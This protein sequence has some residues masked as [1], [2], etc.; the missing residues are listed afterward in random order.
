M[1][2]F[3][4]AHKE[5]PYRETEGYVPLHVG[6]ASGK[7]LPYTADNTGDNISEKN[8]NFCEL[9]GLYW[10]WKNSGDDIKGLVHYR[11]YFNGASGILSLEEARNIL[12]SNDIILAK[13]EYL[14]E[15]AYEEFSLHSGHAHDLDLL[16]QAVGKVDSSYLPAYD[17]IF[18][19]NRLHLYNMMVAS[20]EIFD[21]YCEW[22]FAVLFELE[23]HVC[24][25]GYTPYEQ[26]LYGFLSERLLNVFVEHKKLKV[27][28]LRVKNTEQSLKESVKLFLRRQKNRLI[29]ALNK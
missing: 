12:K 8:P 27:K 28:P 2:I 3:I 11:R 4:A 10:I 29:F 1:A 23:K 25:T 7:Q 16:R 9:T 21:E 5:V 15:N 26:R 14:R 17:K 13:P 19:G 6:A 18:A 20:R 24:M 22:L